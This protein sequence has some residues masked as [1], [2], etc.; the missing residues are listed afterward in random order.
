MNIV[1]SIVAKSI[2][3]DLFNLLHRRFRFRNSDFQ[4]PV[5]KVSLCLVGLGF[6]G[7]CQAPGK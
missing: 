2:N 5:F 7:Q 1:L 3:F 4:N 6:C